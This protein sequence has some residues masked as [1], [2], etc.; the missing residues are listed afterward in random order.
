LEVTTAFLN[1]GH[2]HTDM[3]DVEAI[4]RQVE[5]YFS[6]S[7]FRRDTFLKNAAASDPN[8][9][10]PIATLLTF[11]RL[12]S[13]TTDP[14]VVAECL[15]DSETVD[16]S[17]DAT[18]LKRS[19]ELPENDD[20]SSRTLYVKGYPVDDAEVTIESVS[21]QFS[22][23]GSVCMVRMR[24]LKPSK[25]FKGSLFIEYDSEDAVKEAVKAAYDEAGAVQMKYKETAFACVMH[26]TAW[27]ER[28]EAKKL[29]RGPSK[30]K[31]AKAEKDTKDASATEEVSTGKRKADDE[32]DREVK[33]EYT[34]GLIFHVK[35]IPADA[36][37]PELKD[38]F[39]NLSDVKFVDREAGAEEAHVR[40][41]DAAAAVTLKEALDGGV[42]LRKDADLSNITYTM[43]EGEEEEKYWSKIVAGAKNGGGGRG[44]GRGGRGG[45][46]GGRGGR[47]GGRGGSFKRSR[48]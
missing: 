2:R 36:T 34:A 37:L 38:F 10:V 3:A 14:A 39:K 40:C 13:L 16:I 20:S 19:A 29:N 27:A 30:M 24:K 33:V 18:R 5:F 26:Y 15:K 9:Y 44:G 31:D 42:A 35:A 48:N 12:K 4:K 45:G 22:K 21:E 46:R 7:N 47:G 17:D 43:L 8:G 32:A 1:F 6:D 28:K 41:A 25:T 23:F 11:N